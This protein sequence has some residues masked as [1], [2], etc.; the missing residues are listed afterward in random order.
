MSRKTPKEKTNHRMTRREFSR[1]VAFTA[2]TVTL[3]MVARTPAAV[4][5]SS[6]APELSLVA[7]AQYQAILARYGNR[8]ND[9]QKNDIKRLLVQLQKNSEALHSFPLDNSNEPATIF[10]AYEKKER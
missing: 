8:L 3:P 10:R 9:E 7:Q 1:G 5:A 4:A 2:A 6:Q